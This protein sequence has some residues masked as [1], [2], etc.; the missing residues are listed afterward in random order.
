MEVTDD[1]RKRQ[2]QY[3]EEHNITPRS[4][5]KSI[6]DGLV[7]QAEAEEVDHRL[8]KEA[9]ADYDVQSAI[10]DIQREM[11]E[12]AEALEFERAAVLRDEMRELQRMEES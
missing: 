6:A 2:R 11:L 7:V 9:R 4:I 5:Q 12:A 1:R 10:N 8:V 3:N